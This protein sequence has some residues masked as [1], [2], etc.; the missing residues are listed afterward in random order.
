MLLPFL[1]IALV[2]LAFGSFLNVCIVRLPKDES[3]V[4]PRSHCPRCQ[5][6]IRWYDNIPVASYLVLRGRCRDCREAISP[7]YPLVEILTAMVFVAALAQYQLGLEFLKTVILGMLCLVLIFTDLRERRIPHPVTLL[8]V[9]L[10]LFFSFLTPVDSRP[11]DWIL[12]RFDI[13]PGAALLSFLGAV[14]GA[15]IG[16]G[17]F[18]A[19]GTAFYYIGRKQKE[20]LGFG[21]VMLMF[22][23]GSFLGPS[24]TLLTILLGSLLGTALALPLT[25]ASRKFR[26]YPW[27]YGTFLGVAAIYASLGGSAL[28]EIYLRW[29]HLA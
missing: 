6:P 3:I 17:L 26:E 22:M 12:A 5:K 13:A 23:V 8:G 4:T 2:G 11:L 7:I 29:S 19:V 18:Y 1:V 20:Y 27:P 15:A 24:L 9:A 28:I 16:G 10:G 14:A 21:D 25:L